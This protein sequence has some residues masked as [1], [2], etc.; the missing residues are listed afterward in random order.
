M[1]RIAVIGLASSI[2]GKEYYQG[3]YEKLVKTYR[4]WRDVVIYD[5]PLT[6]YREISREYD[7]Y[8]IL[9]LT[10]GTS[11]LAYHL[12]SNTG[13]PAILFASGEHNAL[14]SALSAKTRLIDN[15]LKTILIHYTSLEDFESKNRIV[16]DALKTADK[17]K[18]LYILEINRDGKISSSAEKY[19]RSIG[20]CVEAISYREL[21]DKATSSPEKEI[22]NLLRELQKYY[23]LPSR[24][25]DVEKT[26]R[27]TYA[28][29]EIV[30]EKK[31]DVVSIDCFPL[32]IEYG[33]TPC[34]A[35][36]YITGKGIPVICEDDFYSIPLMYIT[37]RLTRAS[38]WIAN[39]SGSINNCLRF[40]HCTIGYDLGNECSFVDHFETGKPF[41][42]TCKYKYREILF[43]RLTS[44]YKKLVMYRGKI[45]ESGLLSRDYCRT[46]LIIETP[47]LKPD[48][49][50]E[51][52]IG[53]HHVFISYKPGIELG[54]KIISWWLDWVLEWRN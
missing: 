35:V 53:N 48:I 50:Y 19:M 29:L 42:I 12:L 8:I 40:A 11:S 44:D 1:L 34:L 43:G 22:K 14:A 23:R 41:A 28:L 6:S 39:P 24:S 25:N 4:G 27:I 36:S 54:L 5:K 20:G 51:E 38:G 33:V 2:H 47:N 49:F 32:I 52:A 31:Y 21:L 7:V 13:K 10:G 37:W 18:N 30:N 3:L 45:V 46:Q 26:A 17:L 9:H 16:Y 15:G